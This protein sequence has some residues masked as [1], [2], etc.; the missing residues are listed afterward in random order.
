MDQERNLQV[1][2]RKQEKEYLQR[3]LEENDKN[4]ERQ[5]IQ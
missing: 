3:M 2:K 1:E 4:K 5:K